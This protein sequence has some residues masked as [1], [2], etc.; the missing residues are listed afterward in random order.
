MRL[1]EGNIV[2]NKGVTLWVLHLMYM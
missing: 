2:L 1:L